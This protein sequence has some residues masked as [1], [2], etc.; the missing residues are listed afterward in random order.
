[1]LQSKVDAE[2]VEAI[3]QRPDKQ[4]VLPSNTA[5]VEG[6]SNVATPPAAP[7][8]SSPGLDHTV[9]SSNGTIS[10]DT[11]MPDA[12]QLPASRAEGPVTTP[13]TNAVPASDNHGDQPADS[14]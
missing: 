9:S 13:A 11:P 5:S 6:L 8:A 7:P 10:A 2:V 1:M 4:P 12:N 3:R 14:G